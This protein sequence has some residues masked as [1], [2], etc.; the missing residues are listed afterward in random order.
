MGEFW[1]GTPR[2]VALGRTG[3]PAM[4]VGGGLGG[5]APTRRATDF[6]R[7]FRCPEAVAK[8]VR[9]AAREAWASGEVSPR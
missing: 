1:R 4:V 9:A 5:G 6:A 3:M 7:L 8:V 2:E